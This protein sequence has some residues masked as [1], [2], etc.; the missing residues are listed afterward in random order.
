MSSEVT[1]VGSVCVCLLPFQLTSP[2][3]VRLTNDM[4]YSA[5]NKNHLNQTIF[6]EK[7]PLQRSAA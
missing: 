3:F 5:G 1:V 2:L 4:T 7:A 6:S